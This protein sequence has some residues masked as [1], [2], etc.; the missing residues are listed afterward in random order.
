MKSKQTSAALWA[1]LAMLL[2][3]G[4]LV[5]LAI[6]VFSK[7]PALIDTSGSI[8]AETLPSPKPSFG[9]TDCGGVS[10]YGYGT[11]S[12]DDLLSDLEAYISHYPESA[13][14]HYTG[15]GREKEGYR[16]EQRRVY[17]VSVDSSRMALQWCEYR[18]Q[19][20]GSGVNYLYFTFSQT[21]EHNTLTEMTVKLNYFYD[22]PTEVYNNHIAGDFIT[23]MVLEEGV[24]DGML[25]SAATM[26]NRDGKEFYVC[27]LVMGDILV[28]VFNHGAFEEG[29]LEALCFEETKLILP[30]YI[31]E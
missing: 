1:K 6:F 24:F 19:T 2:T 9:P 29:Q 10:P 22:D 13:E 23:S 14:R 28:V 17:T 21:P 12:L 31:E 3:V 27:N 16:L 4:L 8:P 11:D 20:W 7:P 30:V 15:Y 18:E 25:Y 5:I 26:L